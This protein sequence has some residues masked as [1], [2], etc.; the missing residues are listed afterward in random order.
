MKPAPF[1]YHAPRTLDEV[2]ARLRQA[3]GEA[4]LLAGGQ[5]LVPAMNL[6]LARPQV[7]IDLGRVRE[8]DYIR[9]ANDHLA[10]G[11]LVHQRAAERSDAVR[12]SV[13]LLARAL[14]FI[15]HPAIRNRGTIGG[16]LAHA[17]PAAELPAVVTAL[18]ADLVIAGPGGHRVAKPSEFF[19]SYLTTSLQ[20]DEVLVEVRLPRATPSMRSAFVE[21][22][23]RHGDFAI[24]GVALSMDLDSGWRCRAARV[25]IVGVGP[26]P[27]RAV[28]ADR[29][30][31]G[32]VAS[33]ALFRE[34]GQIAAKEI[35]PPSDIHATSHYRRRLTAVLL[36]DAGRQVLGPSA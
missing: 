21:I 6:R 29:C 19:V 22:S 1:E 8:L 25:A 20:P 23:R 26:G 33:E 2:L 10:V 28:Q 24:V 7:L 15:G 27:V 9:E 5:S 31:E 36:E 11:A 32:Q 12:R 13:P 18:D 16:S 3:G 4:K 17:D 34:A 35:D 30:L 14:P